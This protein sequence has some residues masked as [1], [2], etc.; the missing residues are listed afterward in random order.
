MATQWGSNSIAPGQSAGWF[1]SRANR[2]EFLPV[3]QVM[4]LSPSFTNGEWALTGGGYPYFNQLGISTTW[5]ELSDDLQNLVYHLVVQNNS[6]NTIEYAFL[7]ADVSAGENPV[8]AP[9]ES[10]L[11]SNS[12]YFL[13]N[14]S[15]ILDLTV[16]IDVTEDIQG[17]DG[18]SFQVNCYSP[19]GVDGIQQY[20]I[21]VDPQGTLYAAV[22]NWTYYS[23]HVHQLINYFPSIGSLPNATLP[24]GYSLT[25][26]LKNDNHGNI[27]AASYNVNDENGHS[28]ASKTIKLLQLDLYQSTNPVTSTDLAPIVAV[29]MD[30]VDWANGNAT[31]LSS[32]A[33]VFVFEASTPMT[34]SNAE[35]SCVE[36]DGAT[37]ER[38]N[39]IYG[40]M[41]A[42]PSQSMT[43]SF[44]TSAQV[45][46]QIFRHAKVMHKL[47][48]GDAAR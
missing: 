30:F 45:S 19:S 13:C 6:S 41:P 29:T 11:R 9:P 21:T 10:G 34:V 24:A 33:G 44:A 3:L 27:T 7:E 4:P 1:F 17:S 38:A 12:N 35:P 5:S 46:P 39:S 40:Q 8:A 2:T 36:L 22:D 14:C 48:P 25:I 23:G 26:S 37:L 15:N 42:G 16:T 31:V 18:F 32:G 20:V 43:Q 28:V 47:T